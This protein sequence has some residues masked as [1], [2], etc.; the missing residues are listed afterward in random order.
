MDC[1]TASVIETGIGM[2]TLATIAVV[3]VVVDG[4]L[5]VGALSIATF[6]LGMIVRHVWPSSE[7]KDNGS[8][9]KDPE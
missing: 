9:E 7:V 6:G 1:N 5:G 4:E 8:K 3:G 2:A